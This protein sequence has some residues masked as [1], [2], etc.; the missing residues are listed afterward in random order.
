MQEF[1]EHKLGTAIVS[2]NFGM[3]REVPEGMQYQ[4][5]RQSSMHVLVIIKGRRD[6]QMPAP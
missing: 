1:P 3:L 2:I 6:Y 4:G 5:A